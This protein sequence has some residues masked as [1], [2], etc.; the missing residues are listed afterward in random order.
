MMR[1][2]SLV[3]RTV[4]HLLHLSAADTYLPPCVPPT[5]PPT[6]PGA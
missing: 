3:M 4:Y 5:H 6:H 2:R 1:L